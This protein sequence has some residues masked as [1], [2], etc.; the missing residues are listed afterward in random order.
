M[1]IPSKEY[2]KYIDDV[3]RVQ[4]LYTS[5]CNL[6]CWYC[7]SRDFNR[8][9]KTAY[10]TETFKYV[11]EYIDKYL[12]DKK[13]E[14]NLFG[15]EPTHHK[16]FIEL[17]NMI[18]DYYGVTTVTVTMVT[19]FTKPIEF[20]KQ[21]NPNLQIDAS[22]HYEYNKP[23]VFFN[24]IDN[25]PQQVGVLLLKTIENADEIDAIYEKYKDK[26]DIKVRVIYQHIDHFDTIEEQEVLDLIDNIPEEEFINTQNFIGK[27]CCVG[28]HIDSMGNVSNCE[29]GLDEG[30]TIFNKKD[31]DFVCKVKKCECFLDRLFPK[32]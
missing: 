31:F 29:Y 19:N 6:N 15:G 5:D 22:Y 2:T 14:I 23:E 13:L 25:I 9:I 30:I 18:Y 26:Y 28:L 8:P 17:T 20:W 16:Q 21:V 32:L 11:L 7:Y 27:K 3:L 24:K 4:L 12:G 10:N 1:F